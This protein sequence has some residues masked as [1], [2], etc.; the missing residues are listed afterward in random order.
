MLKM[1][2]IVIVIQ[3]IILKLIYHSIVILKRSIVS[4]FVI[5]TVGVK[6]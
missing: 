5:I 3:S 2:K 4:L 1:C 6:R